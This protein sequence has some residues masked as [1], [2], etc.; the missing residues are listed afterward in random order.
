MSVV[1]EH[2]LRTEV[3]LLFEVC[4]SG[5]SVIP[6]RCVPIPISTYLYSAHH[7]GSLSVLCFKLF[8]YGGSEGQEHNGLVL[9]W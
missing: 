9:C 5:D 1:I 7:V 4:E 6:G 8:I 3:C 2:R